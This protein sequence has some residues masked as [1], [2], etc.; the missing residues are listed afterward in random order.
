MRGLW[1]QTVKKI[2]RMVQDAQT[3]EVA[4]SLIEAIQSIQAPIAVSVQEAADLSFHGTQGTGHV[5][6]GDRGHVFRAKG[7]SSPSNA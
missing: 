7:V 6:Y 1:K 3:T 5:S 2:P 4:T